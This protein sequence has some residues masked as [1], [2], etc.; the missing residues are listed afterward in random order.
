ME[1]PSSLSTSFETASALSAE[2]L[3]ELRQRT[4]NALQA[5]REHAARLEA[6]ITRQLDEIA[7]TLS[8][9]ANSDNEQVS[10]SDQ[11][12]AEIGRLQKSLDDQQIAASEARRSLEL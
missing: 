10:A 12:Q 4:Q 8:E 3:R 1:D 2:A 11:H 9:Q 5:S 6:D 7:A